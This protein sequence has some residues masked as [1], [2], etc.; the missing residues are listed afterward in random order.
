MKAD[1]LTPEQV[2][3][4]LIDAAKLWLAHDG[5]W[6]QSVERKYGIDEAI[7]HDANAWSRFS[8]IEAKRIKERIGLGDKPGLEGLKKAL[9]HRLYA[10][11]NVQEIIEEDENTIVFRMNECRV[12][13][14]RKR[15]GLPD[16]PCKPVGIIEYSTFAKTIDERIE[17]ECI[18]CP[19]DEHPDEYYCAWRFRLKP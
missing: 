18:C 13:T 12:Q 16:F 6:F 2:K 3:A 8:P 17:T 14:A 5:L 7:E 19:P 15:K 9:Q 11:L 4:W 1:D 10:L